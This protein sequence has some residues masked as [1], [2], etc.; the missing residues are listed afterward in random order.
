MIMIMLALMFLVITVEYRL[1]RKTKCEQKQHHFIMQSKKIYI[2][3][4]K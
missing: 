3:K 4:N 2:N 1:F